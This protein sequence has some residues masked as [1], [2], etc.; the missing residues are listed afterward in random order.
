MYA[1]PSTDCLR[2]KF[3]IGGRITIIITRIFPAYRRTIPRSNRNLHI[4]PA[5][6]PDIN[7]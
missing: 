3:K 2:D 7:R 5:G 4:K 1:I 6:D